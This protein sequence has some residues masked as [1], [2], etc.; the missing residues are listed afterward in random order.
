VGNTLMREL[1]RGLL[2]VLGVKPR[3]R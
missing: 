3:R 1:T 2:G